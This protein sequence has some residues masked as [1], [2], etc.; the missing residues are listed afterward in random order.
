MNPRTYKENEIVCKQQVF[1]ECCAD[2]GPWGA[3]DEAAAHV[4][5]VDHCRK[6]S[7]GLLPGNLGTHLFCKNQFHEYLFVLSESPK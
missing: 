6:P 5:G 3:D 1:D 2:P 4:Q 7:F